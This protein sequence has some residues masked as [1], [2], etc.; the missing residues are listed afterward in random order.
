MIS[1]FIF[2]I[3]IVPILAFVLPEQASTRI[4]KKFFFTE[5]PLLKK[6]IDGFMVAFD[7]F[8]QSYVVVL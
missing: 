2:K 7:I 6:N 5:V 3:H 4:R 8:V 1:I